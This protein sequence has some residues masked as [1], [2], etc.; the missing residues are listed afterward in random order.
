METREKEAGPHETRL[1]ADRGQANR[2]AAWCAGTRIGAREREQCTEG[3]GEGKQTGAR[4][5]RAGD[6]QS[7]RQ[8][9]LRDG[10]ESSNRRDK[11]QGARRCAHW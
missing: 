3:E 4:S 5:R 6:V 11:A 1:A 10:G 9:S 2:E 8:A 7:Q